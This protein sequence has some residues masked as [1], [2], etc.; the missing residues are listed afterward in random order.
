MILTKIVLV[1]KFLKKPKITNVNVYL[2][3]YQLLLKL[4]KPFL[5]YFHLSKKVGV[6]RKH[7]I[8]GTVSGKGL[9]NKMRP[10]QAPP[11]SLGK[12]SQTL[13]RCFW[14]FLVWP[15]ALHTP[16]NRL[17]FFVQEVEIPQN[18]YMK[19]KS[20]IRDEI[21]FVEITIWY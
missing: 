2:C 21:T 5:R 7:Y 11:L 13:A 20:P 12:K 17:S 9:V 15:N 16:F 10:T 3:M 6:M 18:T 19:K 4:I 8:S 1:V 14:S